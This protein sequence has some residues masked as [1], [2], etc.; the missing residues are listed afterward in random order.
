MVNEYIDKTIEFIS[1]NGYKSKEDLFLKKATIF[2]TELLDVNYVIIDKYSIEEPNI[3]EIEC[4]Y[5]KKE[6]KFFPKRPYNLASTPCKNVINKSICSYSSNTKNLFPKDA[7][8]TELSIESYIGIPLWNSKNEPIGLIAIMD[9]EPIVDVKTVEKIIQII[10]IKIENILENIIF[11]DQITIKNIDIEASHKNFEKLSNLTFE[12]ILIHKEG[13]AI[14]VNLS[15]VKMFGYKKEELI[16]KNVV[17]LLFDK[18]FHQ[19]IYNSSKKSH[20]FPYEIYGIRKDNSIIIVEVESKFIQLGDSKKIRV[21]AVRDIS[22]RK[23]AENN[24]NEAQKIANIGTFV[25]DIATGF[26][27]STPVLDEILGID[28][29]FIKN[30]ENTVL[31]IHPEDQQIVLTDIKDLLENKIEFYNREYRILKYNDKKEGWINTIGKLEL[32]INGNPVKLFGTVQDITFSKNRNRELKNALKKAEESEN[33]LFEAQKIA[34]L[35]SYSFDINLD[36]WSSSIILNN[37]FGIDSNYNQNFD[38]WLQLIHPDDRE[39]MTS[40]LEED[41]LTNHMFFDKQYRIIRNNDKEIRWVHGFGKLYFDKN[42]NPIQLIGTIQDITSTIKIQEELQKAKQIA[43]ESEVK[44]KSLIEQ[45]GDALYLYNFEGKILEIN[46][47]SINNTGYSREELLSMNVRDLNVEYLDLEKLKGIWSTLTADKS[48]T[49]ESCHKRKN[50]TTFP[51]E[52]RICAIFLNGEKL[53]YGL[54]RDIS[55][56]KKASEKLKL[57]SAAV[58]QSANSIII[59]DN[60]GDIEFVNPKFSE[61]TGYTYQE[62]VGKNP[63][64]LNS[65]THNE[66]FYENLW[67]TV[68]NGNIWQGQIQNKTKSGE[69]LWEQSTI[70]PIKNELGAITN[71]LAIKVDVTEQKK[72]EKNLKVAYTKIEKN[73]DYLNQILQTANEG[74]WI[75]NGKGETTDVNI[76][77]CSILGYN[78]EEFIGKSIFTFID[79][80]NN[81]IFK[82]QIRL[83]KKGQSSS[84]EIELIKK[85]GNKVICLFNTSPIYD[86]E[87]NLNG[88][89]ALVTNITTLKLASNKLKARNTELNNLSKELF[90][91]NKLLNDSRNRFVNLFDYSPVSLWEEDFFEVKNLIK[92]KGIKIEG[93]EEYF[94]NNHNFLL[95]CISKIKI[96]KVNKNT[97]NL[98]GA[99]DIA[100]LKIH[101]K[102]SNTDLSFNVLKKEIVAIASGNANFSCETEF[103]KT[104]GTLISAIIK[105]EIDSDGKAIVS[106][107]DITDIKNTKNQLNKAKLK[108]EKSDERYRLAV[109][110]TGLGIWDWDVISNKTHYSKLYKKQVGYE[111]D[112]LENKFSTWKDLLH[113]ND[114]EAVEL[115]FDNYLKNPVGQYLSEFRLRHKNGSYIWILSM[116]ESI[117]NEKG[118]VIRMFGSHRDITIRK[119][120]LSKLEK[121]TAELVKSKEKAEESNRLKTEFLNNMSHEIR[122][123]MNGILGFSEFL[124]DENLPISKRNYFIKIIQNSG[125]Q[126]LRVIDDILEI[127]RLETKQVKVIEKPVCLNDLLMELFS[128]FDIKAKENKIPL[129][130]KTELTDEQSIIYTDKSKLNKIV[131]NLLENSLKY[132]NKGNISFGYKLINNKI[133]IFVKDTGIGINLEKQKI[134]FERF[135]Q[136]NEETSRT[137]GGLGLGLSIAKEN[138]ELLGGE[139]SVNSIKWQ[140]ST[141]VVSIPYKPVNINSEIDNVKNNIIETKPKYVILIGEDEEINYLFIEILVS[142]I[143]DD[144]CDILHAKDGVEAVEL[145]NKRADID[146][147]LMDINMPNMNGFEATKIIRELRP[148][149]PIIAQTAY[150]SSED[151][152]KAFSAGCNDFISKPINNKELKTIIDYQLR[153]N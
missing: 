87:N 5:T 38:G 80:N 148:N 98:F 42:G 35:G 24:L 92:N 36:Y 64:I 56:R 73:E 151:K 105:S 17:D 65:G 39:Q 75:I 121:Q 89:F 21:A 129:Y 93:L 95:E 97:L 112:E 107:L 9:D 58:S 13:V 123:P 113:P 88:S 1:N 63:R 77:M 26:W 102:N 91:K 28:T 138:T 49:I 40:Y 11:N 85:D 111:E 43:E 152:E 108:A 32:D 145:C 143:F 29:N 45:A 110:A 101:L 47:T 72:S 14:D 150:S 22:K 50:G 83:R 71:F 86:S 25:L 76:K 18:Q 51:T 115:K 120:A 127:S 23:Q 131:S 48:I 3:A 149:L 69:L 141:F 8:L 12:G 54:A 99:K 61:L 78:K 125:N 140:G 126:L 139:I 96:L 90:D 66:R 142:K 6:K 30:S 132:T 46:N 31:F 146:F 109:S 10:A 33:N 53:I 27:E 37:I 4:F 94:N 34:G 81:K 44:F 100:E 119:K 128:I 117:K 84:Y 124:S 122:T 52:I 133:E 59:T 136:E 62:V 103:T 116:A 16:G 144:N 67:S 19:Q 130:I 137:L 118:E 134:I 106:V 114:S 15:F 7:L 57:L 82:E 147:V 55:I 20:A 74:F 153:L 41:I 60:K 68:L 70:T 135:S 2:L 79:E 104:D